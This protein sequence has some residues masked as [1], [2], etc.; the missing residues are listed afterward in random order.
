MKK[1]IIDFS[2]FFASIHSALLKTV[3]SRLQLCFES[4]V[5]RLKIR[6]KFC[7]SKYKVLAISLSCVLT[8]SLFAVGTNAW[9]HDHTEATLNTFTFGNIDIDLTETGAV[10]GK[11]TIKLNPGQKVVKDP[12]I[13]VIPKSEDSYI[14]VRVEENLV[15]NASGDTLKFSDYIQYNIADDWT[16]IGNTGIYYLEHD[17]TD[18]AT[19]YYI[20]K[21]EGNGELKNGFVKCNPDV[22][23]DDVKAVSEDGAQL[24]T[25]SFTAY[26]VQKG[27]ADNATDAWLKAFA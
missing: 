5:R 21:G 18:D 2:V 22:D 27:I 1:K 4:A 26:A 3:G 6:P 15:T 11:Q 25:L 19:E 16:E 20:I 13:T 17:K 7:A 9:L 12:K 23:C 8:L 10:E 14:Y 24:P